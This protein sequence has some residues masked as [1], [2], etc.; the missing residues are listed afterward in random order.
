MVYLFSNFIHVAHDQEMWYCIKTDFQIYNSES[1]TVSYEAYY[2]VLEVNM[3][4]QL[5]LDLMDQGNKC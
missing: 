5:K 4:N 1:I 2:F 3:H